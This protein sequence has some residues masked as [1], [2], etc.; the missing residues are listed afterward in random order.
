MPNMKALTALAIMLALGSTS[1]LA[2]QE[3]PSPEI[4]MPAN[5]KHTSAIS[6]FSDDD[7]DGAIAQ[8]YGPDAFRSTTS[9][10]A[11]QSTGAANKQ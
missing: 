4:S 2:Y 3:K 6:Q 9:S 5:V 1:A 8:A 10:D 11:S 7:N